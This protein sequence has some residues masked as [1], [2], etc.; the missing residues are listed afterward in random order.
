MQLIDQLASSPR[1]WVWQARRVS[2][3]PRSQYE[4]ESNLRARQRFWE[5]QR[6]RF[7][8]FGWA[9]GL[10]DLRDS[11]D[12]LVLDVGCGN[13]AYLTELT[14][15]GH[16]AAGIDLSFGMLS[17]ARSAGQPLVNADV[18]R[19]PFSNESFATVLAPHMLYHVEDRP[20]AARE[21]RRVLRPGGTCV[22]V[23]NGREHMGALRKLIEEAVRTETPDWEMRN[24]STH[25]FSLENGA[26]V[27]RQAFADVSLV[28]PEDPPTVVLTDGQIAADYVASI[29]DH[30]QHQ[31]DLPWADV[32]EHVR[33]RVEETI[34][35][36]G[37]FRVS[38]V[39]G[40]FVCR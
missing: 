25:V 12:G 35:E 29:A 22:V 28:V 20:T 38:G 17:A 16:R 13:G 34:G 24:P 6:P 18:A 5:S 40:A 3:N 11:Q 4:T 33:R 2:L 26:E 32:V 9:L 14:S 39:S 21:L 10:A 27:L 1:R 30:Y 36:E 23:T 37:E 8:F 19:L 15:L 7:D 31:T